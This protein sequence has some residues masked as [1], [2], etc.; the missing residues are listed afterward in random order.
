MRVRETEQGEDALVCVAADADLAWQ[1]EDRLG[2][3]AAA[4]LGDSDPVCAA[5]VDDGCGDLERFAV[6]D[7]PVLGA[8]DAEW[9]ARVAADVRDVRADLGE[10]VS[11]VNEER[12]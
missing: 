6:L 10:V 12:A 11:V 5:C 8:D 1:A 4:G 9:R 7:R 2:A 3:R